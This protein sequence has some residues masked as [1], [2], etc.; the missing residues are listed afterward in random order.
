MKLKLS[1]IIL[2]MHQKLHP[3]ADQSAAGGPVG[4]DHTFPHMDSMKVDWDC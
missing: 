4:S 2:D 1:A 3:E